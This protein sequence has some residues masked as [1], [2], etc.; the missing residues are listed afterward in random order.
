MMQSG[1]GRKERDNMDPN[2][3]EALLPWYVAGTLGQR[4]RQRVEEALRQDPELMRQ[5]D[6]VREEFAETIHL[7]ETLGAPSP[8]VADR[9]MAAI[10]AEAP[11]TPKRAP[12]AAANWLTGFFASLSPR[13]M[14]VAASCATLVIGLQAILLADVFT[15][16]PVQSQSPAQ[17]PAQAPV[18]RGLG[19]SSGSFAMVRF[20]RQA[21]AGD[22]TSFLQHYQATVVDGPTMGGVYRVRV[23]TNKLPKGEVARIVEQMRQDRVV[24]YAAADE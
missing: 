12:G 8:R 16:S 23:A 11:A 22:I 15:R 20:A 10:D 4:D 6:L 1:M 24:E 7:N 18:Y 19:A 2:E 3:I 14:A 13:T 21:N 9:L 17:S 5:L